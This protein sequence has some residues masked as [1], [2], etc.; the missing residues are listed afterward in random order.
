[1]NN[2]NTVE[3]EPGNYDPKTIYLNPY[4][5]IT[6]QVKLPMIV[7]LRAKIGF[8]LVK[9]GIKIMGMRMEVI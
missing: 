3:V 4:P 1:M 2:P 8:W 6:I 5:S 7:S 9:L